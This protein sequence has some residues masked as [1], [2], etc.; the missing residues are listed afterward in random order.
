MRAEGVELQRYS[1]D[2]LRM[3]IV[4]RARCF[5]GA[6]EAARFEGR[7]GA[8]EDWLELDEVSQ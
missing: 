3:S 1:T 2:D 7:G 6:E 4:Y 8:Q 5:E